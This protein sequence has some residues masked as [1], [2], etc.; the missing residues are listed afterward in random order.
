MINPQRPFPLGLN[1]GIHSDDLGLNMLN[2]LDDQL[3]EEVVLNPLIPSALR[4]F[5]QGTTTTRRGN[6][7]LTKAGTRKEWAQHDSVLKALKL[8]A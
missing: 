5:S 6:P 8:V 7:C 1:C 3:V 4:S 2:R